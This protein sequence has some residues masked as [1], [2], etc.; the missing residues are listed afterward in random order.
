VRSAV[1]LLAA[2]PIRGAGKVVAEAPSYRRWAQAWDARHEAILRARAAGEIDLH[3]ME[4]DY[5][6][7][8]GPELTD[9]PTF[10][11]NACAQATT[12][13]FRTRSTSP[14]GTDERRRDFLP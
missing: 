8:S 7:P 2:Y 14:A 1:V 9:E 12:A 4:I 11:Y 5:I 10:W 13:C 3:I 6:I